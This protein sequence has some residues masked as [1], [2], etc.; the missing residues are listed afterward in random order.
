[1]TYM[2]ILKAKQGELDALNYL[3]EYARNSTT[4]LLE[5][6]LFQENLE[7]SLEKNVSKIVKVLLRKSIFIDFSPWSPDAQTSN[8]EHV[9]PYVHNFLKQLN[10]DSYPVVKY[11]YWDDPVYRNA[12][13]GMKFNK[14]CIRLQIDRGTAEDIRVDPD[15]VG[16]QLSNIVRE[17]E[18]DPAEVYLLIDFGDISN[19]NYTVENTIKTTQLTLSLVKQ[20]GFLKIIL[21]GTSIPSSINLAI[22]DRDSTGSVL[23]KEIIVWQ[24]VLTENPSLNLVFADYGVRSP[25]SND[26][27]VYRNA[28][29]K[30][31]YTTKNNY[32]VFRGHS[33]KGDFQQFTGL[34]Q[35]VV[36]SEHYLGEEF[37]WGDKEILAHSR[38]T[39]KP[40]NLTT[41]IA[42][43][44]NHH[45][46]FVVKECLEFHQQLAAIQTRRERI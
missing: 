20:Y 29:A 18:L 15:H 46:E 13:S 34:A 31:R 26:D 27:A 37:S 2:P 9:I 39:D 35:K 22:P 10:V 42:I 11:G 5:I 3:T 1:M 40:G 43:D 45:I 8:G 41:W 7:L 16:T 30:I 19:Q 6:P 28:N 17:L 23:R 33:T 4:P 32:S 12:F 14:C 24:T 44:T 38:R 21:A 25:N 36:E